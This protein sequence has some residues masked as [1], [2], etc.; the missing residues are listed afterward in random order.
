VGLKMINTNN[1]DSFEEISATFVHEI[2]NPISLAKANLDM[3]KFQ[4]GI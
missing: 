3:I 4:L 2:K 1:K